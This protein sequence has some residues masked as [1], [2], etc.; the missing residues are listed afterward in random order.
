MDILDEE[1][2][3]LLGFALENDLKS[4]EIL[5]QAVANPDFE[6]MAIGCMDTERYQKNPSYIAFKNHIETLK[7]LLKYKV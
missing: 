4:A 6:T 1:N 7:L 3:S 2:V 5:L